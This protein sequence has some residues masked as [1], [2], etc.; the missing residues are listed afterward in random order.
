M[1][2]EKQTISKETGSNL[3]PIIIIGAILL[4][5]VA[6]IY[7]IM[8]SGE[9]ETAQGSTSKSTATGEQSAPQDTTV[10]NYANA[11]AGA[12]PAN[13]KGMENSLVVVEEFADFQ[14]PTCAVVHPKMK[15][16]MAK[17]GNR[18]KFV[19][20]NYP[21]SQVH[22]NA[23]R[24]A[25]AA[26]AA[27][28]QGKFWEMQDLL[29]TNQGNWSNQPDPLKLFA[30]YAKQLS[31]DVEKFNNDILAMSTKSRVDADIN[32]GRT[33]NIT[34]TPSVLINGK[35]IPFS[36]VEVAGL[37]NL[38]EAELAKLEKKKDSPT[39]PEETSSDKKDEKSAK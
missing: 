29:F 1:A 36:Q 3:T 33:L 5:T 38:I 9:K 34:S 15:E 4:A 10:P 19:F 23:Y 32:R 6:G 31:L 37:S 20:R 35:L 30:D 11:P 2:N 39:K 18:V 25:T 7:M 22:P 8:S 28:L 27:G 16:V 24:A 21:L 13:S 14:C 26:E 17:Y 12:T